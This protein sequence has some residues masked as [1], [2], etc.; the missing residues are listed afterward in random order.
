MG[1]WGGG[2]PAQLYAWAVEP[3]MLTLQHDIVVA[4][5]GYRM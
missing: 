3:T 4:A 5:I 2:G 1:W